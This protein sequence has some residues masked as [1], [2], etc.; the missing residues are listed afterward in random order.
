VAGR[1]ATPPRAIGFA[2]VP[3]VDDPKTQRALDVLSAAVVDLQARA[4]GSSGSTAVFTSTTD[5]LAPLSGG[6]TSNFLRADGTWAAPGG[7]GAVDE[8]TAGSSKVTVSPTTGTVVVDVVPANFTGIPQAGVT[9]LVADLAAKVPTTRTLNGTAPIR[10][11][12]GASGTLAADRTISVTDNSTTTKGV[13]AVAPNDTSKFWR[14]DAS[15]GV[16]GLGTFFFGDG[17]DGALVF[18]GVS[19]VLGMVPAAGVYTNNRGDIF[20]TDC[21]IDSGVV[22]K[23]QGA[24]MFGTGTLTCNGDLQHDGNAG[25]G[26]AVGGAAISAIGRFATTLAGA[27]GNGNTGGAS[28]VCW[29][30]DATSATSLAGAAAG[31]AGGN[32]NVL[33]RGGGGGG[34]SGVNVG[35]SGGAVT[36]AASGNGG[37]DAIAGM[38]GHP[39]GTTTRYSC[40]SG[41]GAGGQS[42]GNPG[43]GGG[44]GGG[45]YVGFPTITGSG[46]IHCRGGAGGAA[47]GNSGS[48]GGGGGGWLQIAY[49]SLSGVTYDCD[50]GAPGAVPGTGGPG[51]TG[52]DGYVH[53]IPLR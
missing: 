37:V 15:W 31:G 19:N 7:G 35:G 22:V 52:A 30:I 32:G 6:G 41:G 38:Q 45:M 44:G 53:L 36:V 12:G 9:S 20:C 13:V 8:V 17:R 18:D 25:A 4:P 26:G 39:V 27:T 1:R 16:P 51:G 5:G 14:G 43:G 50:G 47:T 11:D 33:F 3:A 34:S 10:I 28:T 21:T 2:Q 48:G 29:N 23:M 42:T 40:G 46:A 24:A 49:G